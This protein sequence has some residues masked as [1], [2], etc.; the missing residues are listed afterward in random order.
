M[1]DVAYAL[2][3]DTTRVGPF[4]LPCGPGQAAFRKLTDLHKS[5]SGQSDIDLEHEFGLRQLALDS[6]LH[7]PKLRA[8]MKTYMSNIQSR[9]QCSNLLESPE[10]QFIANSSQK[11]IPLW[12]PLHF[13]HCARCFR[14]RAESDAY[15]TFFNTRHFTP[16]GE[17]TPWPIRDVGGPCP[18]HTQTFLEETTTTPAS[19]EW[20]I[21]VGVRNKFKHL[22]ARDTRTR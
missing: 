18:H 6:R 9:I 19:L 2:L 16:V 20:L 1:I 17:E 22:E 10:H 15:F 3:L 13:A 12:C 8:D 5:M 4:N 7:V 11:E 21:K 14:A